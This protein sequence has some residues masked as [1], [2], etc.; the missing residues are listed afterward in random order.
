MV[1]FAPN[2]HELFGT[3]ESNPIGLSGHND[4]QG[5]KRCNQTSDPSVATTMVS[6]S[7]T[8]MSTSLNSQNRSVDTTTTVIEYSAAKGDVSPTTPIRRCAMEDVGKDPQ[9]HASSTGAQSMRMAGRSVDSLV[10][11]SDERRG[12]R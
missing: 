1:S 6:S 5:S 7:N 9:R 11:T 2:M 10:S 12:G 8:L 4:K 3:L